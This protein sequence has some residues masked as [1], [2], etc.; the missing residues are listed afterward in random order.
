MADAR[1]FHSLS[2]KKACGRMQRHQSLNDLIWRSLIK[3][4]V[5]ASKEPIGLSRVDGKRP[6]G[7]TLIPWSN[8]KSLVWDVTVI[9]TMAES[10]IGTSAMAPAGAAELADE[11]KVAKYAFIPTG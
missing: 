6:D 11:R 8:G 2:C 1:G 7:M 4:G 5:P 10:Y 9:N 3:A